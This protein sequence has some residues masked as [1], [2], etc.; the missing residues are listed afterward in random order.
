[1][2]KQTISCPAACFVV[3]YGY[4]KDA[5]FWYDFRMRGTHK[6]DKIVAQAIT[7]YVKFL[8]D[9]RDAVYRVNCDSRTAR[10]LE[11]EESQKEK[12]LASLKK[13]VADTISRT[14]KARRDEIESGYDREIAKGQ[15]RLK[16]AR[17][18]REKA[19]DKGVKERIAEETS[20]LRD[21]NRDLK[22]HII[23]MER[24]FLQAT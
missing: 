5:R 21:H 7:D 12:E 3:S 20:Q 10:Q 23:L 15:D 9:A 22:I 13:E 11:A 6:E 1:M 2:E 19:K 8:A 4:T 24:K 17:A 16:K 14:V 18:K